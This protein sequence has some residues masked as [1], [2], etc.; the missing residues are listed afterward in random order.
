MDATLTQVNRN[1]IRDAVLKM[2]N[3]Q[4]IA[5]SRE[6]GVKMRGEPD[7]LDT[8]VSELYK[9]MPIGPVNYLALE[10]QSAWRRSPAASTRMVARM[11][12][13]DFLCY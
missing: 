12:D 2:F 9:R 6:L 7:A 11:L 8:L 4:V 1:L 5:N 10:G 13:S 3:P